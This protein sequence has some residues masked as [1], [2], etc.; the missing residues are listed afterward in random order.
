[1]KNWATAPPHLT[2]PVTNRLL[3]EELLGTFIS[4]PHIFRDYRY[5]LDKTMFQDLWWLY[6]IMCEVDDTEGLTYRGLVNKA[7]TPQIK[8]IQEIRNL[9]YNERRADILLQEIKKEQI[10]DRVR[11]MSLDTLNKLDEGIDPDEIVRGMQEDVFE[12][13]TSDTNQ[14]KDMQKQVDAYAER[15]MK[16]V[17]DPSAAYGLMT[18]IIPMDIITTGW[19]RR[20]FSVVG[21]RT[22]MGKSAFMLENVNR[23]NDRGYKCAVFSL[24]MDNI[25]MYDRLMANKLQVNLKDYRF[26][27]LAPNHYDQMLKRKNELSTIYIEDLRGIDSEY[28]ADTMRRLKRTQGLDFVVVDYL[29]D[30][31]EKVEGND[32]QGSSLARVCRKLRKASKDCDC[33]VMGLSQVAR[34]AEK[35]GDKRPTNSDLSGS[36]GIETSA[37]VIALLYRDD[38]YNPNSDKKGVLEVNFTKQRNGEVGTVELKYDLRTQRIT[39]LDQC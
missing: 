6:E 18:G 35:Q 29:Q 30:V 4:F 11:E 8:I 39:P 32:N 26:G 16:I 27:R 3:F 37:D 20:E 1:M 24:E 28:I 2:E 22:S 38:Y 15:M 23:L 5:R 17:A 14:L 25:P 12:I 36:T 13:F 7:P 19:H 21:A 31:N 10:A 33:H 34:A 9:G